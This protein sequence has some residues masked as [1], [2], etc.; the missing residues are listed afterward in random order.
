MC[1]SIFSATRPKPKVAK[2]DIYVYKFM[3]VHYEGTSCVRVESPYQGYPYKMGKTISSRLGQP[4]H[5]GFHL[6][7]VENGLHSFASFATAK[8]KSD[9]S[10]NRY[11][12][13]AVIPAGSSYYVGRFGGGKS[14]T[15]D[16]LILLRRDHPESLKRIA[17]LPSKMAVVR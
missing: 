15:S 6:W 7:N 3:R 17:N 1:L 8:K 10:D 12:F 2:Q 16:K 4:T 9:F 11:V 14:Y 5:S 13:V